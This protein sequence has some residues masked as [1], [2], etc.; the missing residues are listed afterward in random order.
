MKLQYFFKLTLLTAVVAI[1]SSCLKTEQRDVT[2]SSDAQIYS[3]SLSSEK[4]SARVLNNT[5]FTIDQIGEKIFNQ[6]SLPYLFH[7]DSVHLDLKMAS[8]NNLPTFT[9]HLKNNDSVYEWNGKDSI[10]I[11]RL[12][13]ITSR[14]PDRQHAI[15][16]Q[17][18]INIHQQDPEILTWERL[19]DNY[20]ATPTNDQKTILV[21]GSLITYY[22]AGKNIMAKETPIDDGKNWSSIPLNG[23]PVTV[24]L[25]SIIAA[26]EDNK[27]AYALDNANAVYQTTD[28]KEWSKIT[29]RYPVKSIYGNLP[30]FNGKSE[31]LLMINDNGVS[32]L[33]TTTDFSTIHIENITVPDKFPTN[34][35]SPVTVNNP[36]VFVA[37][38]IILAG[39]TNEK[40]GI[41]KNIWLIQKK[42]NDVDIASVEASVPVDGARLFFYNN[43]L[44]L[45][46]HGRDTNKLFTSNDY[47]LHWHPVGS[48]QELPETFS[49]RRETSIITDTNHFIWIVGG[50]SQSNN[51]IAEVWRGR[52]NKFAEK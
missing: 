33:A 3:L 20:L 27:K 29:T 15:T 30:L 32:K 5:K 45:L 12:T 25:Q 51:G 41:S 43:M 46:S 17:F 7:I 39:G 35:L 49:F 48:N 26:T 14:A 18:K 47:G 11:N 16:Y 36:D 21:N 28:G 50:L 13:A 2:L 38:Y 9:I 4:D 8:S 24:Q 42:N 31:I 19:A 34:D 6:D 1:C 52:L 44:Y 40:C 10:A 37:K 22:R 23:L